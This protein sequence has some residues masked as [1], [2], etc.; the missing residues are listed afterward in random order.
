MTEGQGKKMGIG[1][2]FIPGGLFLGMGTGWAFD[3]FVP[4]LFV[5]LG[6]GLLVFTLILLVLRD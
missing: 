2:L 6:T 5:G 1:A 3:N 4:G